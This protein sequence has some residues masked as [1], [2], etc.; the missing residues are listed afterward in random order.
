VE[1]LAIHQKRILRLMRE[2]QLLVV[3]NGHLKA[4]RTPT[5]RTPHPT[6]P[7]AWWGIEMTNVM[8]EGVGWVSI[9]VVL[10]WYTKLIVGHDAGLRG[11]AH[12]WLQAIDRAIN[13]QCPQGARG[14][15]LSRMSDHG[16][17]P[18]A[19]AFM[20]AGSLLGIERACTSDHNPK[21][22]ADTERMIRTLKEACLWLH[23]WTCPVTFART[24]EN[25]IAG[26]NAHYLHSALGD[27]SPRPFEREYHSSHS[28]PFVAA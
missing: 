20:Q 21:G 11:T 14:Q 3:P 24:L 9:V 23:E 1:H 18:T 8:V 10:D 16:C 25:W 13:R 17:Q 22:N 4:T 26:Y 15:G 2:H 12:H 19:T 6:K 28:T 5:G 7:N 27:K